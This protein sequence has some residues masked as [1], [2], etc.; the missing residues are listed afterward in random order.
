MKKF[1]LILLVSLVVPAADAISPPVE[2]PL[3]ERISLAT[4]IVVGTVKSV[5]HGPKDGEKFGHYVS[6]LTIAVSDSLRPANWNVA[7]IKVHAVGPV[8]SFRR[9]IGGESFIYI[10]TTN[11]NEP[12][13]IFIP[14]YG[15]NLREAVEKR[16]E[17]EGQIIKNT[18]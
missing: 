8:E 10:L 14:S 3:S 5:D 18:K 6:I 11:K 4:H 15:W 16:K 2:K 17:I 12:S 7:E 1:L 13:D 9:E